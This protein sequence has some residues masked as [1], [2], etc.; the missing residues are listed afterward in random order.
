M[1]WNISVDPR[2]RKMLKQQNKIAPLQATGCQIPFWTSPTLPFQISYLQHTLCNQPCVL[3]EDQEWQ[4]YSYCILSNAWT[5]LLLQANIFFTGVL[6]RWYWD[7]H[8][9]TSLSAIWTVGSSAPQKVCWWRQGEWCSWRATLRGGPMRTPWSSTRPSARP[10]TWVGATPAISTGWGMKGWRA[11]LPR[12][13]WG[14]WGMKSWTWP[15]NVCL[16]P[17]RPPV[18]W[19]EGILPLHSYVPSPDP[20]EPLQ[21]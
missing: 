21:F 2:Q 3:V 5:R 8:C 12:K 10:R 13:T 19:A 4:N 15:G 16:Q 9:L 14:C 7:Q 6:R 18:L 20:P 11:A 1:A 17:R